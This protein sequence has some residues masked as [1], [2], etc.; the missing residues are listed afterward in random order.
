MVST[1]TT[2]LILWPLYQP[3]FPVTTI[4]LTPSPP[5]WSLLMMRYASLYP[6]LMIS[7]CSWRSDWMPSSLSDVSSYELRLRSS[8]LYHTTTYLLHTSMVALKKFGRKAEKRR[9]CSSVRRDDV[10]SLGNETWKLSC[11]VSELTLAINLRKD[12]KLGY[13]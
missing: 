12:S 5:S 8:E 11:L 2:F 6:Y 9:G 13:T 1:M 10:W 4:L 7:W 3:Q